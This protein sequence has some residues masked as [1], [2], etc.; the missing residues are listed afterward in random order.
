M[1]PVD[2]GGASGLRRE[3]SARF[4]IARA[5]GPR[6][7][8]ARIS[9]DIRHARGGKR[10]RDIARE[11]WLSAA[12]AIGAT[13]VDLGN[14]FFEIASGDVRV[15]VFEH[16]PPLNDDVTT[17]LATDKTLVS[18]VLAEAGIGVPRQ[19]G[20][21]RDD[22]GRA[23]DFAGASPEER[24][25]V[26]P[27]RGSRG[28]GVTSQLKRPTDIRR[29]IR[30]AGRFDSQLVIEQQIE[31]PACRFLVLDGEPAD[32][33]RK[34]PPTVTG[35]GHSSVQELVEAEYERRLQAGGML[36]ARPLVIDY[37]ALLTLRR[38]GLSPRAVPPAGETVAVKT[39]TN[40]NR[41]DDNETVSA[42]LESATATDA[43]AAAAALGLRLAGVDIVTPDPN[44]S[45]ADAGGAIVDMN[46]HP[47]L[48][49]HYR[50][51][52]AET[53]TPVAVVILRRLLGPG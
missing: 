21:D 10:N 14:G 52:K 18:R 41:Q 34:H 17:R 13:V 5:T 2:L 38:S 15:R 11:I 4:V 50:V 45:L 9:H 1:S 30:W 33:V 27:A 26:K 8:L 48:A 46:P 19:L 6:H 12:E 22:V 28:F 53:A 31:G 36:A 51:R 40:Q 25:V 24:Y 3:L 35:D 20:F 39:V 43:V 32:V 42:L 29:A 7:A 16:I 44:R 49:H 47:G 23:L 37:D